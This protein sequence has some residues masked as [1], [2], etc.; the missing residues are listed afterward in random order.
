MIFFDGNFLIA[1]FIENDNW[2]QNILKVF[3]K[4]AKKKKF[5]S[6]LV[7]AETITNLTHNLYTKSIR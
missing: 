4:I 6:K 7:I 5:I 1:I 3:S 2:H